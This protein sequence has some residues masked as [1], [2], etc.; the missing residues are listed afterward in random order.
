M[1]HL[2]EADAADSKKA[3]VPVR[4]TALGATIVAASFEL[5]LLLLLNDETLFCHCLSPYSNGL[6]GFAAL[7][8]VR[9]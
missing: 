2:S 7:H 5:R 4:A 9:G 6:E 3:D 1:S 8:F